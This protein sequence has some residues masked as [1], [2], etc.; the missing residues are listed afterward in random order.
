MEFD[1]VLRAIEGTPGLVQD[2]ASE[3]NNVF[4]TRDS[5]ENQTEQEDNS[6]KDVKPQRYTVRPRYVPTLINLAM[7][8]H[9]YSALS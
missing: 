2:V 5:G 3:D 1:T 7:D 9:S 8:W 4:T 6:A